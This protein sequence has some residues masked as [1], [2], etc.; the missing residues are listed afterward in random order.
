MADHIEL[1]VAKPIWL[2]ITQIG[3]SIILI[4]FTLLSALLLGIPYLQRKFGSS[5][6]KLPDDPFSA[7]HLRK[8]VFSAT[9]LSH[10]DTEHKEN[11]HPVNTTAFW[12]N[13]SL[14]PLLGFRAPLTTT[15]VIYKRWIVLALCLASLGFQIVNVVLHKETHLSN[16]T[17]TIV[18]LVA[19]FMST[20]Y[21][22]IASSSYV[23]IQTVP[24]HS[25][26]TQHICGISAM[27]FLHWYLS[28]LGQYLAINYYITVHWTAFAIFAMI[29]AIFVQS[30]LISLGPPLYQDLKE[31]YNKA[32]TA[33]LDKETQEEDFS[34]ADHKANL[35]EEVSASIFGRLAFTFV[36]PMISK[37]S[38]LDQVDIQDL[39]APQEY[40][41][42]QNILRDSVTANDN[43][44]LRTSFGPTVSLLWTVWGPE[45]KNVLKGERGWHCI[46]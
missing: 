33:K 42:T 44:G 41:R 1:S 35:C 21:L 3:S 18:K 7:A 27:S 45:W 13:V 19:Q 25:S 28:T 34:G 43:S 5:R 20:A 15:Q 39:P 26:L 6:V 40:F 38:A 24:A 31:L 10:L 36:Y 46:I 9:L 2:E 23:L 32:V 37:S 22:V 29:T 14:L 30:G 12:R 4:L 17:W 16:M 8:G 11:G